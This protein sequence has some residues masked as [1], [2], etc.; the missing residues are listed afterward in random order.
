[1]SLNSVPSSER[2]HISFFGKT[3]SGKSS[4]INAV[5]S[6]KLSIVSEIKGTTTDPVSKAMEILPLGAVI[7][8]DTAGTDDLGELGKLRTEKT[9]KILDTTD[10]AIIVIDS[11]MGKT[12][13]DFDLENKIKQKNIPYLIC[14][15]KSDLKYIKPENENE[16][17]VSSK[18]GEGI[19]ELK[20]KLAGMFNSNSK[21]KIVSDLLSVGDVAILVIPIDGSAPK[22][23]LILPQQQTIRDLLDG[24]IICVSAK[25]TELKQALELLKGKVSIV[26]TDSQAFSFVSK[27]VPRDIPLTSFSILFLRYKGELEVAIQGIKALDKL[28]N[29]SR[30]LISEGCTHHRQCEDIGT[31]KIPNWIR[32][33]TG[34][35]FDFEFT[36]GKEFPEELSKYSLVIHCGGCMLSEREMKHRIEVCQRKK[37]PFT[38]YGVA[39]SYMNG[40]LERAT[41]MLKGK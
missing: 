5:T 32:K 34:K 15:N 28:D 25:E 24:G 11:A 39:I 19:T 16:I 26:I 10:I 36:S 14:Y 21:K 37:V 8:T 20:N 12:R 4:L 40:I 1:M 3:N 35:N 6:Q 27:I 29:G 33:Y 2:V 41:E 31:V 23:R 17:S 7:L 38:N 22:G 30:I 9:Y 18:N 13:E